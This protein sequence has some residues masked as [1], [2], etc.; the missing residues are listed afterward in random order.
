MPIIDKRH[1]KV[2]LKAETSEE[3][4]RAVGQMLRDTDCV[5]DTFVDAVI[6]R[7]SVYPTGMR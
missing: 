5:K 2:G 4:L 1:V 7:E 3:V 6:E